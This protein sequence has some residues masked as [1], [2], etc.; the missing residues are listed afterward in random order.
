MWCVGDPH[1]KPLGST[2]FMLCD[3][4]GVQ[5]YF[6]SDEDHRV[7]LKGRNELI[8]Q[9]S[10]ATVLIEVCISNLLVLY[11]TDWYLS[12]GSSHTP[13]KS[14]PGF[15]VVYVCCCVICIVHSFSHLVVS[16]NFGHPFF[17]SVSIASLWKSLSVSPYPYCVKLSLFE[18]L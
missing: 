16:I 6:I 10:T 8:R 15:H 12:Q 5:N 3:A 14:S 4:P 9:D 18:F 7:E 1:I 2:E 17:Y 13:R 11:V